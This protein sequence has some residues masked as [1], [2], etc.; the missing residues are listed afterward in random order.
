VSSLGSNKF[1]ALPEVLT[2]SS[3]PVDKENIPCQEDLKELSYL[4]TIEADVGL[5]IR[6]NMPKAMEPWKIF[7]SEGNGP[8]RVKTH[9]EWG[10]KMSTEQH[11][12]HQYTGLTMCY[13]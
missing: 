7:N 11:L 2:Q 4:T 3:I 12:T 1:L 6:F 5:L 10:V 13:F 8:Y 9:L